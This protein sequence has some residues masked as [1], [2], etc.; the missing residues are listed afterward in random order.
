MK[1]TIL[2]KFGPYPQDGNSA[3]SG[4]LIESDTKKL[5]IDCG[6]GVLGRL[7]DTIN[8][9]DL[10][11]IYLT[12]LH[13]DHTSDM[14]PMGYL[15]DTLNKDVKVYTNLTNNPYEKILF[16][17]KHYIVNYIS[18]S[19]NVVIGDLK[20]SFFKMDHPVINHGVLIECC[21]VKLGITG[22]TRMCPNVINLAKC[23]DYL[24]ADCS[25][26]V[27]FKG[28]HMNVNDAQTILANTDVV[29]FATHSTPNN[30]ISITDNKNI[31]PVEEFKTYT[32]T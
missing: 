30:D 9:N 8:V 21:G 16:S 24:L 11:A 18:E 27:D 17:N 3:C 10:D 25:K 19:T 15:L 12:H 5:L 1:L 7:Q 4:Y 13:Y 26:P 28:P 29:I 2:G 22:D 20:L 6:S 31:I 14:L 23:S 32:L